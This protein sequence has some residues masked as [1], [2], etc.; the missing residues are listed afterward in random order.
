MLEK[1]T[2]REKKILAWVIALLVLVIGYHGIWRPMTAKLSELDDE[3]FAMEL[4]LR[5][6][7][8]FVRQRDEILE[9]SKKYPNL[10]QMDAG[11]DQE[12]ITKLLTFIEQT[13]RKTG[14]SISDMKPQPVKSDKI[15]KRYGVELN[16]ESDMK[17]LIE[18]S[19]HL[20]NS[21]E[22]LSV[23][24]VTTSPKEEKSPILRTFL[25]VS[26]VVVK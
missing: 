2:V 9:M 16:A 17:Q 5:K 13:A 3:I 20:Q 6:A 19:Y 7:K 21:E 10:E 11:T 26:R 24:E 4:K 23:E 25:V 22:L 1:L 18:F 15:T 8:V 12:E 14:V